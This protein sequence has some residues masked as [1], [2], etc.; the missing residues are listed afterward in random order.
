MRGLRYYRINGISI[1]SSLRYISS[2][3]GTGEVRE[4][5]HKAEFGFMTVLITLVI[6]LTALEWGQDVGQLL[7]AVGARLTRMTPPT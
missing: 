2:I 4:M 1:A 5:K 7:S 3:K 6:T